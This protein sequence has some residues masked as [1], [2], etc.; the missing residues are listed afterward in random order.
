[1]IFSSVLFLAVSALFANVGLAQVAGTHTDLPRWCGKAY[2]PGSPSFDPTGESIPPPASPSQLL[3]VQVEP[4]YSI[5]VGSEITGSFIV[6]AT[7]SKYFGSKYE[8]LINGIPKLQELLFSIYVK[9]SVLPLVVNSVQVNSTDNLFDFPL[10]LLGSPQLEPYSITLSGVSLDGL[11][12]F[13]ATT[14]IFYLPEKS[15]GSVTKIDNLNGGLLFRGAGTNN[16]FQ[17]VLPYGFYGDYSGYFEVNNSNVQAYYDQGF[18]VVHLVTSFV[19]GPL[20]PT[21]DYLDE[22]GLKFIYD[23]R[24]SFMNLTSVAYQVPLVKDYDSFLI[25]YTG[26]EPDGWEYALNS[27]TL[28]YNLITSLDKYH[29]VSLVLNCQDFYYEDY[30]AGADIVLQDTYPIGINATYSIPFDT[31]CNFTHGDCGCD[32]CVGSLFDV[33]NRLDDLATYQE[34]LGEWRKPLWSVLQAFDG[35]GYWQRLPTD[36]ETWVMALLSFNHGAKGITSWIYPSTNALD[37]AHGAIAKVVTKAP[38]EGFLTGAQPVKVNVEGLE[39]LDIAY[40]SVGSQIMAIVASA[41]YVD[42]R[43]DVTV[44]LPFAVRA[45]E[46]SPWGNVT[47]EL[48]NGNLHTQGLAAL[49][50]SIIILQT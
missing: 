44:E 10:H 17:S 1:M 9:G 38:V 20:A 48:V 39:S 41:S 15:T 12:K 30:A 42:L 8:S 32:N 6:D 4:R 34:W 24:G 28:A 43:V 33:S 16:E 40:W 14:E 5:Y 18:N 3:Y 25:Y 13:S 49:A 37:A 23:M 50:T 46:S 47:W 45:I 27:T 22:I 21:L 19:D 31:Y 26:D 35:E 2:E 11:Q 29:P 7:L 36:L